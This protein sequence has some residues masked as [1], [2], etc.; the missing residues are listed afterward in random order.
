M[1]RPALITS[2]LVVI[3]LSGCAPTVC[4][5]GETQT[6]YC[7]AARPSAQVCA[8]DGRRWQSCSCD[9]L[10]GDDDDATAPE[11]GAAEIVLGD[12]VVC[13]D[14]QPL[15]QPLPFT[16]VTEEAGVDFTPATPEVEVDNLPDGIGSLDIDL[17]G[18]QVSADLDG[19]GHLDL[20]YTDSD[21]APRL[22]LGDGDFGFQPRSAGQ[23]GL[24]EGDFWMHGVSAADVDGDGDL[25]L[26]FLAR[27]DNHFML[28]Q[29][30][31]TFVDATEQTGLA[32]GVLRSA[33]GS[34][35]DFD[36]DGDLDL[37]VANHGIGA[38]QEMEYYDADR[39]GF[40]VQQDDGSFVDQI[41]EMYPYDQ[42]GYGFQGAWFDADQDGRT[43]LYVVNDM[44]SKGLNVPNI[45][46]YNRGPADDGTWD[47]EFGGDSGL[48]VPMLGM[49]VAI[50]DMDNDLDFDVHVTQAG[51]TL[52][53]R[54]DHFGGDVYF[55][56]ISLIVMDLMSTAKADISYSTTWFDHDNDGWQELHTTF[57]N[58]PTKT[59]G[60]GPS[61]TANDLHQPDGLWVWDHDLDTYADVA[62]EVGVA[63]GGL[64]HTAVLSDFDRDGFLDLSVFD[65]Y[66]GPRLWRSPCNSNAWLLVHLEMPG[67]KNV[68]AIGAEIEAWGD[69]GTQYLRQIQAGLAG[70]FSGGPPEAHFGLADL[71]QVDLVVRWPDGTRTVNQDV[72]TR[73]EVWLSR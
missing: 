48:V 42:D 16:D 60:Y 1:L 2:G 24:P 67:T 71:E 58:M 20:L 5:P 9:G 64:N 35:C 38:Y 62:E 14:P 53:A 10:A 4:A 72:P 51:P 41:D 37:H 56:D 55:T 18:G 61:F 30:D 47:W 68:Y 7:P 13:A 73:R 21:G 19:D 23:A 29:G 50:G 65:I 12:E 52:L 33:A 40:Y 25:D 44:A 54:N 66:G 39:D 15:D 3:W 57:S 27:D 49:G 11:G 26:L 31:A 8:E 59:A 22:F 43:D 63:D 69:D 6:C 28:N 45:M 17:G 46:L 36:A 34:W 70:N 32:G